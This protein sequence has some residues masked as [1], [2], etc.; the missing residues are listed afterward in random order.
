MFYLYI[1]FLCCPC[2]SNSLFGAVVY[3]PNSNL[4]VEAGDQPPNSNSL[5]VNGTVNSELLK[6]GNNDISNNIVNSELNK[7]DDNNIS[8]EITN[9]KQ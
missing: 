1:S 6:N 5:V 8:D 3:T 2:S 9:A 4:S 7:N